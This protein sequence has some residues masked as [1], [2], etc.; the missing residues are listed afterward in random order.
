MAWQTGWPVGTEPEI[1]AVV[2]E[3]RDDGRLYAFPS[4]GGF[5]AELRAMGN[6]V[7]VVDDVL[8]VGNED[9][10]ARRRHCRQWS[11]TH[12]ARADQ[13]QTRSGPGTTALACGLI[14]E[15]G[16]D[17]NTLYVLEKDGRLQVLIEWFFLYPL[18]EVARDTFAFPT[19]GTLRW[20]ED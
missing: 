3:Q 19:L 13:Q 18:E 1:R 4:R 9:R 5:R 20:R 14:G 17:H 6:D 2:L 12:C 16:W 11:A 7:L 10:P 8:A 15:Y